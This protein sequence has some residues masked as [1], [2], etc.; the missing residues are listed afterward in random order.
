MGIRVHSRRVREPVSIAKPALLTGTS[1]EFLG[2]RALPRILR[3]RA[4]VVVLGPEGS[5]KTSVARRLAGDGHVYLD[6]R[7][8]QNALVE[9]VGEGCW[10]NGLTEAEALVLDGP[11]WLRNRPAAVEAF[12]QL[13]RERQQDGRRTLACQSDSDGSIEQLIAA[14]EPG[15]LVVIGLR[16][17]KGPRGRLRFARRMAHEMGLDR[18]AARGL[19]HLDPWGYAAVIAALESRVRSDASAP[20]V[21]A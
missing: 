17:P 14:M 6:T 21:G 7:D 2:K 5:G 8:T 9:R 12:R 16:F 19:E 4:N 10:S 20:N 11:I 15:S 18:S 13:M 1:S 3:E